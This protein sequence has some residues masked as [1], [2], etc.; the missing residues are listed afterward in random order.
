MQYAHFANELQQRS[1]MLS[2]CRHFGGTKL[3]TGGLT[4]AYGGAARECLRSAKKVMFQRQATLY[5]QVYTHC[6]LC[7]HACLQDGSR[8]FASELYYWVVPLLRLF[9]GTCMTD[10]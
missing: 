1:T 2:C 6:S 8:L 5:M 9:S 4:R 10:A 3:G 7:S